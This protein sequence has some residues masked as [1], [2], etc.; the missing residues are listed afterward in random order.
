MLTRLE[1]QSV[2]SR[3]YVASRDGIISR[4][5]LQ[6]QAEAL[7]EEIRSTAIA[8][9]AL[10]DI[11]LSCKSTTQAFSTSLG[12][13]EDELRQRALATAEIFRHASHIYVHR[14]VSG[15]GTPLPPDLRVSLETALGLLTVVPDALGPGANLGWCLVVLGAELD[16][17]DQRDYIRSRWEGLHLL[18]I[19]KAKNGRKIL[20][21]VWCQRDLVRQGYA[22][23]ERWQDTMQRIGETQILV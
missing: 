21:E 23:P 10:P 19:Y 16:L 4:D 2:A 5:E 8:A 13:D 22:V 17:L 18:G 11:G 1:K 14:I 15:P 12:M 9:D 7:Q 20:E 6:Q 3:L